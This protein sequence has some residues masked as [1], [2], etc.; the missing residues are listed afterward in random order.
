MVT[1]IPERDWK[2]MQSIKPELL[3][4]LCSRIN[5]RALALLQDS[6]GT[7]YETYLSL[8]QHIQDSDRV[9]A[10]CF[11]DWRRSNIQTKLLLLRREGLLGDEQVAGLS[12]AS[13]QDIAR[14]D[15]G[16]VL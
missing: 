12:A 5:R 9:V 6:A 13:R 14:F 3:A 16:T 1:E 8:Y 4:A 11:N 10:D 7:E 15:H 2:Y